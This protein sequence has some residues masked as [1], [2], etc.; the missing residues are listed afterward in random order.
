[1]YLAVQILFHGDLKAIKQVKMNLSID[2]IIPVLV[3]ADTG[4]AADWLNWAKQ[5]VQKSN[6]VEELKYHFRDEFS[7]L[8]LEERELHNL[9]LDLLWI[10]TQ[11]SRYVSINYLFQRNYILKSVYIIIW[12]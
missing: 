6:E 9:I 10:M 1:M 12:Y 5:R 11:K 3:V 2:P 4:G 7:Q 8:K